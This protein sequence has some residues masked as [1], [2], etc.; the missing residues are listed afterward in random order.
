KVPS[1][2]TDAFSQSNR[3]GVA[4]LSLASS[5]A[6]LLDAFLTSAANREGSHDSTS[7]KNDL[8]HTCISATYRASS[9]CEASA[10]ISIGDSRQGIS[11]RL[12]T[13]GFLNVCVDVELPRLFPAQPGAVCRHHNPENVAPVF[14]TRN[15]VEEVISRHDGHVDV[16]E[17]GVHAG[18]FQNPY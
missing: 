3:Y 11:S 5:S 8:S 2:A 12:G 10:G 13:E 14:S 7:V 6:A 9:A 17:D 18:G 1:K 16:G 4:S 15:L